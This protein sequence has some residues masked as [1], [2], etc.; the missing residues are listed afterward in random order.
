[1]KRIKLLYA[2]DL[3]IIRTAIVKILSE[4]DF[5][6][7]E[8]T[9]A[10]NCEEVIDL[11]QNQEFDVVIIGDDLKDGCEA[12]I[13]ERLVDEFE[14]KVII[15]TRKYDTGSITHCLNAGALG[16]I[17]KA[18]YIEELIRS[19]LAVY[20]GQKFFSNEVSQILLNSSVDISFNDSKKRIN[21][22]T[23]DLK[24]REIEILDLVA[25]G[26]TD[27]EIAEKL[28]ISPRTVGNYRQKMLEKFNLKNSSALISYAYKIGILETGN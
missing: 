26:L 27:K 19:V 16:Y 13:T 9:E 18:S 21:R 1:M 25:E 2:E 24:E 3:E 14:Q 6:E 15:F 10:T 23:S 8:I 5:F 20:N 28:F 22:Y 7:A 11:A 17:L 4:Q 12:K